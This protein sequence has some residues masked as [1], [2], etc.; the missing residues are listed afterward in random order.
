M[1]FLKY[2][3][4]LKLSSDYNKDKWEF[5]A[6]K[7]GDGVSGWKNSKKTSV[8]GRF[9]L[10]KPNKILAEGQTQERLTYQEWEMSNLIRNEGLRVSL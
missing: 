7:Q 10:I 9:F 1:T 8:L 6:K 5:I 3:R 2:E 4:K